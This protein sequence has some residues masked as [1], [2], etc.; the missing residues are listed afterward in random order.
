MKTYLFNIVLYKYWLRFQ[1]HL[2]TASEAD[3]YR[4]TLTAYFIAKSPLKHIIK[5]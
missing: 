1:N 5:V 4:Q 3:T 2:D